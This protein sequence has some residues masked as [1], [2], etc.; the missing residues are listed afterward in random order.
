[1]TQR[2]KPTL[3]HL[4][5]S[6][7]LCV[8][9]A[10]TQALAAPNPGRLIL[11]RDGLGRLTRLTV[12]DG[13]TVT[14]HY[15]SND[16]QPRPV[17]TRFQ[18][19]NRNGRRDA[20]D[21]VLPLEEVGGESHFPALRLADTE[22]MLRPLAEKARAEG[23]HPDF[24]AELDHFDSG[25]DGTD[26]P[27]PLSGAGRDALDAHISALAPCAPA[28]AG[29][30]RALRDQGRIL[31]APAVPAVAAA[32]VPFGADS[33]I[34]LST[35]WIDA[36]EGRSDW[37][38]WRHLRDD[39]DPD[40]IREIR[41]QYLGDVTADA[42]RIGNPTPAWRFLVSLLHEM[43]HTIQHQDPRSLLARDAY[44]F[45]A[46]YLSR[47]LMAQAMY[48]SL[49]PALKRRHDQAQKRLRAWKQRIESGATYFALDALA[50]CPP[51]LQLP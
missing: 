44:G 7:A 14:Y 17:R 36:W 47:I 38:P 29:Q 40:E 49:D 10:T 35:Q 34:L 15:P 11:E 41:E 1:M 23:A 12:P 9:L 3:A 19:K 39:Q 8:I 5:L 43:G 31:H 26:A 16:V 2:M 42:E 6:A 37:L 51:S 4:R 20:R 45:P 50:A 28:A 18:D 22:E 25:P 27:R 46:W 33:P 13:E 21:R 30:L 32:V 24:L 48:G